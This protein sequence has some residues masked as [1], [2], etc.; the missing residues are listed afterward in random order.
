MYF[1]V[2]SQTIDLGSDDTSNG[3]SEKTDEEW[4]DFSDE[5]NVDPTPNNFASFVGLANALENRRIKRAKQTDRT[6][7]GEENSAYDNEWSIDRLIRLQEEDEAQTN[8]RLTAPS[9]EIRTRKRKQKKQPANGTDVEVHE[10]RLKQKLLVDQQIKL[11]KMQQENEALIKQQLK[12]KME[13]IKI[14]REIAEL[15]LEE[16]K[17]NRDKRQPDK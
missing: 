9:N 3:F 13:L 12:E 16:K 17:N 11:Q 8:G 5:E 14:R 2:N 1:T 7:E 15:E 4:R 10:L 6:M